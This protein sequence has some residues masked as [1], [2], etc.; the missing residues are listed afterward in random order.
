[1][2]DRTEQSDRTTFDRVGSIRRPSQFSLLREMW[3]LATYFPQPPVAA[4]LPP[5]QGQIVLVVPA[6]LTGNSATRPLRQFLTRCGYRAFG[7]DGG[8]NWGPRPTLL[9]K[10]RD[11]VAALARLQGGPISIIGVSLGGVYARL[12]A[13]DSAASLRK[14]ITLVSPFRLPTA[15][16][17]EPLFHLCARGHE[18]DLDLSLLA[19]PL[20]VPSV[21]IFTRDDGI[22]AW[23]SCFTEEPR[24]VAVEVR[25]AHVTIC[26]NPAAL[27]AVA[28]QLARDDAP[29]C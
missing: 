16:T 4:D 18:K 23:E 20:P 25:G 10:L 29:L 27:R 5:G 8:I 9:P 3:S 14:V 6:F 15:S 26:R 13:Y 22:V 1:M 21:A 11:R 19:Q 7:W 2:T 28:A 24:G 12:V 17:I